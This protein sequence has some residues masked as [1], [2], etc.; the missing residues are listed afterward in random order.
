MAHKI[1][2]RTQISLLLY[3]TINLASFTAGVYL[4]MLWP[5][6][7]AHAGFWITV[8]MTAS[9]IVAA[10]IAWALAAHVPA[11]WRRKLVAEPSPLTHAP[12]E[13]I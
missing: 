2:T 8:V 5:T 12:G 6:F 4:V 7:N 9:V 10:P 11:K 13:P 1:A 3:T